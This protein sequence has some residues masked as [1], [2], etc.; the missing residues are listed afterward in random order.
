MEI[1]YNFVTTVRLTN[2]G[3]CVVHNFCGETLGFRKNNIVILGALK[4]Q[5]WKTR[6]WKT[7]H[8]VYIAGAENAGEENWE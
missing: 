8:E 2:D 4:T 7:R 1:N 3:R 6:E 5:E